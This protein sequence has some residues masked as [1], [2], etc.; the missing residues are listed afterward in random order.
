[1]YEVPLTTVESLN[2]VEAAPSVAY[3]DPFLVTTM[4]EIGA[5]I[6]EIEVKFTVSVPLD[7]LAED[8]VGEAGIATGV[9]VLVSDLLD[10]PPVPYDVS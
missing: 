7:A 4:E 6:V 10:S 1:M 5:A 2:E 3:A 8:I 9:A